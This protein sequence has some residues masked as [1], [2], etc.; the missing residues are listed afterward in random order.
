MLSSNPGLSMGKNQIRD[1][2]RSNQMPLLGQTPW[3]PTLH[4]HL[5]LSYH[6]ILSAIGLGLTGTGSD[7][8]ATLCFISLGILY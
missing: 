4:A 1:N 3:R 8:A 6:L 7:Y 5:F 2:S